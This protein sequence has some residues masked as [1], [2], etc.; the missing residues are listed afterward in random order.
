MTYNIEE[1][2]NYIDTYFSGKMSKKDI[3]K[4]A[5]NAYYDLLKGSYVE[6]S[7]IVL[8]PFLKTLSRIHIDNNETDYT[9]RRVYV[10]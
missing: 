10:T 6:T 5:E 3:G 9:P 2:C 4:W 8:Y 1:L 7:K